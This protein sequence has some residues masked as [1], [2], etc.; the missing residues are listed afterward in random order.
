MF[1]VLS[2][3]SAWK[4]HDRI[5]ENV[6]KAYRTVN[7]N[8]PLTST[9]SPSLKSAG[10]TMRQFVRAS[11]SFGEP[12]TVKLCWRFKK[13]ALGGWKELRQRTPHRLL[14]EVCAGQPI[15]FRIQKGHQIEVVVDVGFWVV[16]TAVIHLAAL[17]MVKPMV[18][19][20]L[21]DR[22]SHG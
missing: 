14:T 15:A 13:T 22:E 12:C 10:C 16:K 21:L 19:G 2:C 4:A 20:V 17:N 8:L 3:L 7:G 6:S 1:P 9:C 18:T 5:P 11:A